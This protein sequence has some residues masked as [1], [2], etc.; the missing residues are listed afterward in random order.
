MS[1]AGEAGLQQVSWINRLTVF[2]RD[3]TCNRSVFV[4]PADI[5][6]W[7]MD[8]PTYKE[9]GTSGNRECVDMDRRDLAKEP[10]K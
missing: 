7:L 6:T 4:L 3:A 9:A 8:T 10:G 5:K 2:V 1:L